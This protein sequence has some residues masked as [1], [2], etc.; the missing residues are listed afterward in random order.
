LFGAIAFTAGMTDAEF[1]HRPAGKWI[2]WGL[3]LMWIGFV[4]FTPFIIFSYIRRFSIFFG[5]QNGVLF[6]PLVDW[7]EV[8]P[9]AIGSLVVIESVVLSYLHFARPNREE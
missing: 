8:L 5:V 2:F 7:F 1:E 4:P 3:V 9:A 6:G